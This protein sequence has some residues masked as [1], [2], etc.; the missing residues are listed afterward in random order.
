MRLG[1]A[2]ASNPDHHHPLRLQAFIAPALR[3]SSWEPTNQAV[4]RLPPLTLSGNRPVWR[5]FPQ[6]RRS[7]R[8]RGSHLGRRAETFAASR[9]FCIAS[10]ADGATLAP[11]SNKGCKMIA[12]R[13]S[14]RPNR[15]GDEPG[16]DRIERLATSNILPVVDAHSSPIDDNLNFRRSAKACFILSRSLPS[17]EGCGCGGRA[18]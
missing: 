3:T 9:T 4:P 11:R 7:R 12:E 5:D 8:L 15:L 6:P 18:G 2:P 13:T 1:S 16:D 10:L 17:R 14:A